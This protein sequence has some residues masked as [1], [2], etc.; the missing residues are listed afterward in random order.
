MEYL[1]EIAS[2]LVGLAGGSLLTLTFSKKQAKSGGKIVDQQSAKAGGDIVGGNKT[3]GK[4][5]DS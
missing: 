5:T 3:V 4:D 1:T 2:F